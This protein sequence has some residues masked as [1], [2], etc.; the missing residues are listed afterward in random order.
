MQN[1]R[2]IALMTLAMAGFAISDSLIKAL[3][4]TMSIGQITSLMGIVSAV[5]FGLAVRLQGQEVFSSAFFHRAVVIRNIAEVTGA[6]GFITALALIPLATA[7]SIIQSAPLLVTLGAVVFLGERVGWRRWA[8]IAVG[9]L[10]VLII[11]RPGAEGFTP[12]A[13]FAVLGTF[14]LAMR[15]L[16]SRAVPKTISNLQL[17]TWGFFVLIPT[18]LLMHWAAGAEWSTLGLSEVAYLVGTCVFAC[19]GVYCVTAA[20]R[21]GDVAVISP[22]RYTRLIFGITIAMIFFGERPDA[23]TWLGSAIVVAAGLYTFMRE[24]KVASRAV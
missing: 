20:M 21:M 6:F 11:I 8:A 9:F 3:A 24:R 19:A 17:G 7:S 2:G 1:M 4:A 10:G 16:A 22:F 14:G 15:D 12:A 23:L 5:V 18:G 13:L